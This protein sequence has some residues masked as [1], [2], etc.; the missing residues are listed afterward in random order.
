MENN[1]RLNVVFTTAMLASLEKVVMVQEEFSVLSALVME[2]LIQK[3]NHS[4]SPASQNH[5]CISCSP[6]LMHTASSQLAAM[7]QMSL[8]QQLW[9]GNIHGCIFCARFSQHRD[10]LLHCALLKYKS[11]HCCA[12][13]KGPGASPY[14]SSTFST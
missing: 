4:F 10:C 6:Y 7:L 3:Q 2:K 8:K 11:L 13:K 14:N 9:I 5:T 1:C 12:R